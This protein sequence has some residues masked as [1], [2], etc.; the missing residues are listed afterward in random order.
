MTNYKE[1]ETKLDRL[2]PFT[3]NSMKAKWHS[4]TYAVYSYDTII[5]T[6]TRSETDPYQQ[7]FWVTDEK[8]SVTT[9]RHINL[10]KRVWAKML[11]SQES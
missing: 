11:M 10:V 7:L 8:Y 2:E 4:L 1:I 5:A 3:G 9:S 6:Y